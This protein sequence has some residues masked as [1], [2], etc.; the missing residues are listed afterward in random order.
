MYLA[1]IFLAFIMT[2]MTYM[3]LD[4]KDLYVFIIKHAYNVI[5]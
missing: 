4:Y 2:S 1:L 3:S 5:S